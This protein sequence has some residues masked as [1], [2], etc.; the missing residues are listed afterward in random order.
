[1]KRSV[2][3]PS[4]H[5]DP[6]PTK[7]PNP[8]KG[9]VRNG[10]CPKLCA[11]PQMFTD[12]APITTWDMHHVEETALYVPIQQAIACGSSQTFP[13]SLLKSDEDKDQMGMAACLVTPSTKTEET[14]SLGEILI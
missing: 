12:N 4:F 11:L 14:A 6:A 8:V 1:M 3:T 10:S 7:H 13:M 2:S 9:M 5:A